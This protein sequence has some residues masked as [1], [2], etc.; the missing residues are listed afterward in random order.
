MG[1]GRRLIQR[2]HKLRDDVKD[3]VPKQRRVDKKDDILNDSPGAYGVMRGLRRR[4]D[5]DLG[6]DIFE[7]KAE[8]AWEADATID[9]FDFGG[10]D[11]GLRVT[12]SSSVQVLA[13]G[14]RAGDEFQI[15]EEGSA[16]ERQKFEMVEEANSGDVDAGKCRIVSSTVLRLPDI[17]GFST[18]SDAHTR[19]ELAAGARQ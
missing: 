13:R 9:R 11:F 2:R 1:V 10:S 12:F 7:K 4:S 6:I 8:S 17:S 18:E 19:V 14:A 15:L 16:L 5:N 3:N